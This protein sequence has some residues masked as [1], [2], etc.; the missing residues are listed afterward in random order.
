[1]ILG[2]GD[3][4]IFRTSIL[5]S[6]TDEALFS[7]VVIFD[8]KILKE[9]FIIQS[10][11]Q[12]QNLAISVKNDFLKKFIFF[13]TTAPYRKCKSVFFLYFSIENNPIESGLA[14]KYSP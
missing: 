9:F 6:I 13:P 5:D 14:S 12:C 10:K 8:L 11:T 2:D 4:G 1:L 7:W 3:S